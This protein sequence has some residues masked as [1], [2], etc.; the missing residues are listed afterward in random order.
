VRFGQLRV[1]RHF[2][3]PIKVQPDVG[4]VAGQFAAGRFGRALVQ[5][6]GDGFEAFLLPL[7][8][9]G[10]LHHSR[11]DEDHFDGEGMAEVE[12]GGSCA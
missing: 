11:I 8:Y 9:R 7:R 6:N 4:D 1:S 10:G 3:P 5:D 2:D 12:A